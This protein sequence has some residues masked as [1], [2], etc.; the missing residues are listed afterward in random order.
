MHKSIM[1]LSVA[2]AGFAW[3]ASSIC[4]PSASAATNSAAYSRSTWLWE[5]PLI[6]SNA[7]DVLAFAKNKGLNEIYLQ[8]NRDLK[9]ADYQTFIKAAG[10]AGI[11]VDALDGR[12]S[13]GFAKS[14]PNIEAWLNWVN[15]YQENA[16]PDEKFAG[17][18]VDIEP[19]ATSA[20]SAGSPGFVEQWQNNVRYIEGRA[21]EMKLPVHA[22]LPF[23]LNGYRT[24]D[25][26]ETL[27][28]WMMRH[29][30]AVTILAYRDTAG[31]IAETADKELEE[32]ADLG[33]PA[34]IGL[35]T[36][37]SKEAAWIT[38]NGRSL[39]YLNEQIGQAETLLKDRNAFSGFAIHEFRAWQAMKA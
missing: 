36:L 39:S 6:R 9:P 31:A 37:P 35:E 33:I 21:R 2:A 12:P 19:Y 25:G 20:W 14:R 17:I 26:T 38:F 8:I 1:L 28:R 7:S 4:P 10:E 18:H 22:D 34:M 16:A 27:S 15:D 3:T 32:A 23:W 5:T 24:P 30:D 29:Y 11:K 13:W